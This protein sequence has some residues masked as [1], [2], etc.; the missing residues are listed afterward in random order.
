MNVYDKL[1]EMDL[2]LPE[3]PKASGLYQTAVI[4]D[5]GRMCSTSGHNCKVNGELLHRGKLG[6]EVSIEQGQADAPSAF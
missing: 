3:P 2:Q 5:G 4:H 6:R 1:R